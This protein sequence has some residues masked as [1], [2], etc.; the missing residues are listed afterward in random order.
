MLRIRQ[1]L[2]G[3]IQPQ[4]SFSPK[5]LFAVFVDFESAFDLI[6]RKRLWQKLQ[7]SSMVKRLLLLIQTLYSN[8]SLRVRFSHWGHLSDAISIKKSSKARVYSS[9]LFNMYISSIIKALYHLIIISP[10]L[11]DCAIPSM[12][13]SDN[14]ILSVFHVAVRGSIDGSGFLLS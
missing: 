13:H 9:P 10:T 1:D 4:T 3:I 7:E 11:A 12:L 8:I 6:P 5:T 14:V 2:K